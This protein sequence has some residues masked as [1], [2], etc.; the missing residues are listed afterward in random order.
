MTYAAFTPGTIL[1]FGG[2]NVILLPLLSQ[3]V[4]CREDLTHRAVPK[5]VHSCLSALS[6]FYPTHR[7]VL[8]TGDID[9]SQWKVKVDSLAA[10][11]LP[12]CDHYCRRDTV[13][14]FVP[15]FAI[16]QVS[17]L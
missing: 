9:V 13:C 11:S 14:L 12:R 7:S 1:T 17:Y 8:A 4:L 5:F 16:K 10:W 3:L 15:L 6:I 2:M